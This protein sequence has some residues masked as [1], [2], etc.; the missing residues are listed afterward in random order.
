[1]PLLNSR[2][3]TNRDNRKAQIIRSH[4]PRSRSNFPCAWPVGTGNGGTARTSN[5]VRLIPSLIY[6]DVMCCKPIPR[7]GDILPETVHDV[8]GAEKLYENVRQVTVEWREPER[9]NARVKRHICHVLV[10]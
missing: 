4:T 10:T 6:E 5:S 2:V 3:D 7:G 8:V 1:M 9:T